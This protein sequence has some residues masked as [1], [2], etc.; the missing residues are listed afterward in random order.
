M[1]KRGQVRR[2]MEAL[3]LD[4]HAGL[5]PL[6][7]DGNMDDGGDRAVRQ[8]SRADINVIDQNARQ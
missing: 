8:K 5:A 6:P 1:L 7:S 2:I 3:R 4:G